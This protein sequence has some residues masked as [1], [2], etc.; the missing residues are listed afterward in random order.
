MA[1]ISKAKLYDALIHDARVQ[2]RQGNALIDLAALKVALAS[3]E[4]ARSTLGYLVVESQG[5]YVNG[6]PRAHGLWQVN[7]RVH[8]VE[9][10]SIPLL[11]YQIGLALGVYLECDAFVRKSLTAIRARREKGEAIDFAPARDIPHM[12]NVAWQYGIGGLYD[13]AKGG[14]SMTVDGFAAWRA[15]IGKPVTSEYKSRAAK[16]GATYLEFVSDPPDFWRD[17]VGQS[18]A[19]PVESLKETGTLIRENAPSL[20][21]LP[22]LP[23]LPNPFAR[24]WADLWA[25]GKTALIIFAGLTVL[26]LLVVVYW[27]RSTGAQLRSIREISVTP[28][29]GARIKRGGT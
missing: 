12:F 1:T 2:Q 10:A 22:S 13:W 15:S 9:H 20:P 28:G 8:K 7:D 6:V 11:S 29:G 4:A 25:I 3:V 26:V 14:S 19:H 21:E 16:F 17:V 5:D 24:A 23:D 27:I 18:V